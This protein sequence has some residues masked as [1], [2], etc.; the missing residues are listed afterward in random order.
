MFFSML[1][2]DS[3]GKPAEFVLCFLYI[4]QVFFQA[5]VISGSVAVAWCLRLSHMGDGPDFSM[6][7]L[8]L[9]RTSVSKT[10]KIS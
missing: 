5:A 8:G 2:I 1:S 4:L 6:N 3:P 9:I 10:G 7:F